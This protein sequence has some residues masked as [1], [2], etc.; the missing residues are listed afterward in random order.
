MVREG[1]GSVSHRHEGESVR[2]LG[3][4]REI[5]RYPVSSMG[6]EHLERAQVEHGGI[7][8][9]RLWGVIDT[10]DGQVAAPEKRRHWRPLPNL[11]S[12][13]GEAGPEIEGPGTGWLRAESAEAQALV[14]ESLEFPAALMPHT[15]FETVKPGHVA[16]RYARADLHVLTT[17]SLQRLAELVGDAREID[18]RRFRPNIVIETGPEYD[19]FAEARWIGSKLVIGDVTISIDEPCSRCSFTA[20]AQGEL[21]FEPAVLHRI[22]E[23]GSGG[24]GVQCSVQSAGPIRAGDEVRLIPG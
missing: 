23:H 1:A 11:N 7:A 3:H 15:P 2:L 9:D 21:S 18:S 4:V 17:A 16:P 13:L 8:G 22:A 6:G 24:F 20:L 5:W 12:R 19:G 10:R 14:S